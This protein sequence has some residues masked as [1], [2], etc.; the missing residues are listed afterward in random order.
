VV[1]NEIMYD[2]ISGDDAD[3]YVEIYNASSK[4]VDLSGWQFVDGIDY[5][6]P[7]GVQIPG[8]GYY[9]VARDRARSL[10][11]YPQLNNANTFGDFD[12]K[13]SHSGEHLALA[14]RDFT[15]ST[16]ELGIVVTN[17][18]HIVISEVTYG[19]GGRWPEYAHG[20][21][22]ERKKREKK[23]KKRKKKEIKKK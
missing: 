11:N 1:I 6:F 13:L 17:T 15:T 18:L 4:A 19:P 2:P 21:I 23:G 14:K 3:Q 16:N 12:G 22:K 20:G 9:V 7:G 8:G 5:E 10:A